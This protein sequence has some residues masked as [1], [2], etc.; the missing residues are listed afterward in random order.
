MPERM[1]NNFEIEL[2]KYSMLKDNL[3]ITPDMFQVD[4]IPNIYI[5]GKV[6]Q[7]IVN[8]RNKAIDNW[9]KDCGID[10]ETIDAIQSGNR[11]IVLLFP[12]MSEWEEEKISLVT[13]D[14]DTHENVIHISTLTITTNLNVNAEPRVVQ[15]ARI[16]T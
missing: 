9:L 2:E 16:P 8:H 10:K 1:I 7:E 15:R 4:R 5:R 12:K 3:R 6:E 13:R 14:K 11:E